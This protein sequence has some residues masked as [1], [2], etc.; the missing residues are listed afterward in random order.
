[1]AMTENKESNFTEAE[2]EQLREGLKRTY[3]ERFLMATRLYKIQLT[4]QKAVITH[5]PFV[6]K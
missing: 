2:I 4:M 5:K 3:K 1:M 6:V